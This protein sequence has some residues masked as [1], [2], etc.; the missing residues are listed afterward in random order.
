LVLWHKVTRH[1]SIIVIAL[2]VCGGW[3]SGPAVVDAEPPQKVVRATIDCSDPAPDSARVCGIEGSVTVEEQTFTTDG[4]LVSDNQY[5]ADTEST[6]LG[7]STSTPGTVSALTTGSGGSSSA[8]GC[9]KVT[10]HNRRSS[11]LGALMFTWDTWTN[12]C[13]TRSTQTIYNVSHGQRFYP[14]TTFIDWQG[15]IDSEYGFYDYSTNDGHPRS[16][17]KNW[18]QAKVTNV[19]LGATVGTIYPVNLIRT[20]YNGTYVWSADN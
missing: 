17:Y 14:D 20:Y 4:K 9:R 18:Q 7:G 16:A 19:L 6:V 11:Y 13:W 2:S 5:G 1:V 15:V 3:I 10:V 12:W 8:S